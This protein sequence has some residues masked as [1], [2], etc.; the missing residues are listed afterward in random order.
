MFKVMRP[1][2]FNMAPCNGL[3]GAVVQYAGN[4][5]I[6]IRAKPFSFFD[7]GVLFY[8]QYTA[9]QTHGFMSHPKDAAIMVKYLA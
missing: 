8:I 1:I 7:K 9:H 2:L 6:N 3:Q 5:T 4:Q